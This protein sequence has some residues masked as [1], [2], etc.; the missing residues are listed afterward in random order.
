MII[1]MDALTVLEPC[2]PVYIFCVPLKIT[3]DVDY[4]IYPELL[5]KEDI[6]LKIGFDSQETG[7]CDTEE[8]ASCDGLT[9]GSDVSVFGGNDDDG[10]D[11]VD[12]ITLPLCPDETIPRQILG[13]SVSLVVERIKSLVHPTRMC[14][15]PTNHCSTFHVDIVYN[16]SRKSGTSQEKTITRRFEISPTTTMD[17]LFRA[18]KDNIPVTKVVENFDK[19]FAVE[20]CCLHSETKKP[21]VFKTFSEFNSFKNHATALYEQIQAVSPNNQSRG[22]THTLKSLTN[23][24]YSGQFR[25]FVRPIIYVRRFYY[26]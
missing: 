19:S 10:D 7:T 18:I 25:G 11:D 13:R 5:Q 17:H 2:V 22:L 15:L 1:E 6:K 3:A 9:T 8:D 21:L 26:C 4:D 24:R 12:Y 23:K 20:M 14:S 16:Y